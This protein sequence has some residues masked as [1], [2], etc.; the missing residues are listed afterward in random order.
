MKKIIIL[1]LVAL[2]FS[3]FLS[4]C[5]TGPQQGMLVTSTTFPG[6]INRSNEVPT[7]KKAE[8][9]AH[10]VLYLVTWGDASAGQIALDNKISRIA[11]VDHS[12]F[13]VLGLV[14]SSYCTIV[15]GE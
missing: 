11:T 1:T 7:A 12:T 8:G 9:C 4:N 15:S 6:E 14:Y 10:N 3:V 5:A 13:S 2:G